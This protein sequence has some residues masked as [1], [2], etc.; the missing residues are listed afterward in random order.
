M[1]RAFLQLFFVENSQLCE[2]K[3]KNKN[4]KINAHTYSSK[5]AKDGEEGMEIANIHSRRQPKAIRGLQL[6]QRQKD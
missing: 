1:T 6:Q 2:K 4:R 5:K 3:D